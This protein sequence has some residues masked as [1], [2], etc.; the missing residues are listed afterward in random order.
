[1]RLLVGLAITTVLA[2]SLVLI[3]GALAWKQ[4]RLISDA[5]SVPGIIRQ[6]GSTDDGVRVVYDFNIGTST[7]RRDRLTPLPVMS[8]H[9]LP[10]EAELLAMFSNGKTIDLHVSR[11][12]RDVFVLPVAQAYPYLLVWAGLC[13]GLGAVS[14]LRRSG[15]MDAPPAPKR[16][17]GSDWCALAGTRTP[18]EAVLGR[19]FETFGW[20][21]VTVACAGLYVWSAPG[22]IDPFIAVCALGLF[23]ALG[24]AV[25]ALRW[26]RLNAALAGVEVTTMKSTLELDQPVIA[27]VQIAVRGKLELEE[28]RL[29]LVCR[30][31]RGLRA[32]R[33]Y[34]NSNLLVADRTLRPLTP[35]AERCTFEVPRRKRRASGAFERFC[36]P[37]M[38]WCFE[39]HLHPAGGG[40]YVMRFPVEAA[41][42]A[43]AP[44]RPALKLAQSEAA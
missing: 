4:Q 22:A 28:A 27:H 16:L 37:R 21:A 15:V 12:G 14:A 30:R 29:A 34:F 13:L 42:T 18:G 26:S 10:G 6:V 33:L 41:M 25:R 11:G 1:M 9:S 5:G 2:L 8:R 38:E 44:T 36:F 7:Y 31:R 39:L 35:C 17:H 20:L 23:P 43:A 24:G 19:L 40:R 32:T 3:G